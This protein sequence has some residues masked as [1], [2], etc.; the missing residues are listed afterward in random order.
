[1][2]VLLKGPSEGPFPS[3]PE[4]ILYTACLADSAPTGHELERLNRWDRSLGLRDG[5]QRK[6]QSFTRLQTTCAWQVI[7]SVAGRRPFVSLLCSCLSWRTR[8]RRLPSHLRGQESAQT[9]GSG[10]GRRKARAN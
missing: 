9:P 1:M 6:M 3:R 4:R 5:L 10:Q 2:A 8:L 7:G